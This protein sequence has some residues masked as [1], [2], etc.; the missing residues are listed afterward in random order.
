[1]HLFCIFESSKHKWVASKCCSGVF[2]WIITRKPGFFAHFPPFV[3]L[4]WKATS[5]NWLNE[6][7]HLPFAHS[8]FHYGRMSSYLWDFRMKFGTCVS[9]PVQP[10]YPFQRLREVNAKY[11][12]MQ[13]LPWVVSY[14]SWWRHSRC[15]WVIHA[16]TSTQPSL[17][18][19]RKQ[20]RKET[21]CG[22]TWGPQVCLPVCPRQVP[23]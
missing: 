18:S 3:L 19:S 1:M 8:L 9:V 20:E 15:N 17:L 4:K 21:P 12:V 11:I 23:L 5:C 10:L 6:V 7:T 13:N 14:W 2:F 22:L 16:Q